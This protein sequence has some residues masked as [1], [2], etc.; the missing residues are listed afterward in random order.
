DLAIAAW[1]GPFSNGNKLFR[2]NGDGTF[3]DVTLAALGPG[4][5]DRRSFTPR[6]TDMNGDR[7]PELLWVSDFY[8]SGYYVNNGDGTFTD[9]TTERGVRDGG[10]GWGSAMF[11]FDNDGDLDLGM[12]NGVDIP[13]TDI[14]A[15]FLVD[16][17]C[18]WENTGGSGMPER[19]GDVGFNDRRMGKALAVFDFDNDGDLDAFVAN[20]NA[21]PQLLRN[22]LESGQHFLRIRLRG[23]F[24]PTEPTR[25][26]TNSFGVGARVYVQAQR[27]GPVQM[28][29]IGADGGYE[30]Q[31]ELVAHF[32]VGPVSRVH[33]VRVRW[34]ASGVETVYRDVAAD[35]TLTLHELLCPGDIDADR[36]V[37]LS[38]LGQ[39]LAMFGA[40]SADGPM[41]GDFDGDGLIGL[42][43][44]AM[45]LANFNVTCD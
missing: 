39:L 44:L 24:D 11:D 8:T 43:D 3:T 30:S 29:E 13:Q 33:E 4:V 12:T 27:N 21:D 16:A 2:N 23:A 22:Q 5:Q 1:Y 10:W 36:F 34:P 28:R 17:M 6:F 7:Y 9:V 37:G 42:H 26:G 18:L 38:D 20:N 32:G 41:A 15:R 45:L 35:Q 14:D 40:T 25:P 19:G 31:P